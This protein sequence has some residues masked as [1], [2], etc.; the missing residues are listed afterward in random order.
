MVR[1]PAAFP[2]DSNGKRGDLRP[3]FGLVTQRVQYVIVGQGEVGLG[4]KL[5]VHLVGQPQPQSYERQPRSLLGGRQL[6]ERRLFSL[7]AFA[8]HLS[9]SRLYPGRGTSLPRK[10]RVLVETRPALHNT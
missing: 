6:A 7:F 9:G 2:A 4:L 10:R 3:S 1:E 8:R 5:T